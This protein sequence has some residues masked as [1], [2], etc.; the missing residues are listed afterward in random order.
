MGTITT[1]SLIDK[2]IAAGATVGVYDGASIPPGA[3][4]PPKAAVIASAA[5]AADGT[6]TIT[7]AGILA[8]KSYVLAVAGAARYV[9][10]RSTLDVSDTGK[11]AGTGTTAVGSPIV[12]ALAAT[13]GAFAVGQRI[14]ALT[15]GIIPPGTR[16]KSMTPSGNKAVTADTADLFTSAAHGY[17][18]GDIVQFSGLTGGAGI[19]TA[20]AYYV[21]QPTTNTFKVSTTPG[22]APLD[23]TST[24]TAGTVSGVMVMTDN[25]LAAGAQNLVGE[26]ASPAFVPPD[27][28]VGAMPVPV[29][30]ST[31]QAKVRQ[32]RVLAGTE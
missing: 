4:G 7:D 30:V 20:V 6:F 12:S 27:R 29:A 22:G 3:D 13:S 2:G 17:I 31:W 16:I 26:G 10:A 25:A 18:V 28:G 9:R 15:A 14:S 19:S 32:R 5:S 23:V 8:G 24:L 11:G 1:G 21:I